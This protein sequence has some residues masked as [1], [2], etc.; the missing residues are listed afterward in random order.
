MTTPRLRWTR[1]ANGDLLCA[2]HPIRLIK[3]LSRSSRDPGW[4]IK[5]PIEQVG[6]GDTLDAGDG[7]WWRGV[8]SLDAPAGVEF[9]RAQD[10]KAYAADDLDHLL[11]KWVDPEYPTA[12]WPRLQ[13]AVKATAETREQEWLAKQ[14]EQPAK[15]PSRP[16]QT[17]R[18]ELLALLDETEAVLADRHS[19]DSGVMANREQRIESLLARIA[20]VVR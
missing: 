3:P 7:Y 4:Q 17:P 8:S 19:V 1:L 18:A 5:V 10:A 9:G 15:V 2:E 20:N 14:P 12:D 11:S 6:E 16:R 13:E